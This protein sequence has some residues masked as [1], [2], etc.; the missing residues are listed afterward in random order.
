MG[1]SHLCDVVPFV[2][3][4]F[5][6]ARDICDFQNPKHRND[7]TDLAYSELDEDAAPNP[8]NVERRGWSIKHTCAKFGKKKNLYATV[9][10]K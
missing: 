3:H 9:I 7:F 6:Y 2:V 1:V 4:S 8:P 5:F 10:A